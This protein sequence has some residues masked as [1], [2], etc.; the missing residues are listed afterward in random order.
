M[1]LLLTREGMGM[2]IYAVYTHFFTTLLQI[3]VPKS[4]DNCVTLDIQLVTL[5][6]QLVYMHFSY[7]VVRH[8]FSLYD[9]I[10][11]LPPLKYVH[12]Y[13]AVAWLIT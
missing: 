6:V 5:D 7:L 13:M 2:G 11:S 9:I 12:S 3:N 10:L 8:P 4:Y 1:K